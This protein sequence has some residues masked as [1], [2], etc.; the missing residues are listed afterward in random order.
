MQCFV[1]PNQCPYHAR[2]ADAYPARHRGSIAQRVQS[3]AMN[4]A[5]YRRFCRNW[6]IYIKDRRA[7][8][9]A[10]RLWPTVIAADAM[11]RDQ[12][13]D[14]QQQR[15]EDLLHHVIEH[16]PF[17]RQWARDAGLA[18][19][20]LPALSD[21]PIVSKRDIRGRLDL[22]Q[23]DAWPV[24]EMRTSRTSGSSGEPFVARYHPN[25]GDLMYCC[26]LRGLA[27]HGIRPGDRRV[28]VWGRTHTHGY[29]LWKRMMNQ[30]SLAIRDWF[31][32][33]LMISAYD[34]DDATVARAVDQIV[35]YKPIY[36]HGYVSAL[37]ALAYGM[38]N[39]NLSN[40]LPVKVVITEAEAISEKARS[41]IE[42][43]FQCRV[44]EHYG[45]V[46]FGNIAQQDTLGHLR[47]VEDWCVVER[48]ENGEAVITHLASH[49][50]PFLRYNLGDLIEFDEQVHPGLPFRSLASVRGRTTDLLPVANGGFVHG[51]AIA[52]AVYKCHDSILQYQVRQREVDLFDIA[53]VLN[54]PLTAELKTAITAAVR[55]LTGEATRVHIEAVDQVQRE[56]SG[57]VKLV[58]SDVLRGQEQT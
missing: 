41:V 53:L 50:F 58:V 6:R 15:L 47:I 4:E 44:A 18:L 11:S 35:R 31:N 10:R 16:V 43:A 49:A 42:Q 8:P 40:K 25:R 56:P 9:H 12:L 17:Y 26:T 30:S 7:H 13:L 52:T 2:H 19:G 45:S 32:S 22:F 34:L 55:R 3:P 46:E 1:L 14:L 51:L 38:L 39:R 5:S 57:K 20:E 54:A 24:S 21:V 37:E 48:L 27:R 28:Y 36:I 33:T 29:S 23:S